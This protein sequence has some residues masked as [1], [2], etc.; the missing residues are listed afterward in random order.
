MA[1][2]D[3]SRLIAREVLATNSLIYLDA[4]NLV[5]K[6]IN[7]SEYVVTETA[8]VQ[9]SLKEKNPESR[10]ISYSISGKTF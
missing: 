6:N 1:I 4:I 9:L 3:L 8:N 5:K 7:K 2:N 10:R